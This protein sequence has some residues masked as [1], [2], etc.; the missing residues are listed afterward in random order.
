MKTITRKTEQTKNVEELDIIESTSA[1]FYQIHRIYT[2]EYGYQF[3]AVCLNST[4]YNL[5]GYDENCRTAQ[6]LYYFLKTE[7]CDINTIHRSSET[8]LVL[9][10]L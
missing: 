10:N 1:K 2:S 6:D 5:I 7:H 9:E 4:A 8:Q 3:V